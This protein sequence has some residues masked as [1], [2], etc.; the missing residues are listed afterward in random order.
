A[1]AVIAIGIAFVTAFVSL[2]VDLV[3]RPHP[4]FEDSNRLVTISL[5]DGRITRGLAVDD[6]HR[7]ATE[8]ATLESPG[9]TISGM[10]LSSSSGSDSTAH[11]AELVTREV[12]NGIGPRIAHGRGLA[13]ED[14]E[15][16]SERVVVISHR[17]WQQ[18]LAGR[19][20]VV[21]TTIELK[22]ENYLLS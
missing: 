11:F 1:V 4:G 6:V 19:P 17:F 12:F 13:P 2:Y 20:D 3:L 22:P 10:T 8:S 5:T 9:G 15:P 18:M 21:G 16:E 7:V 14:H